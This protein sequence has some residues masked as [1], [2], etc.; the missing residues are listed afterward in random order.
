MEAVVAEPI[1]GGVA[2]GGEV[3]GGVAAEDRAAILGE[4]VIADVMHTV[5]DGSP[6]TTD[7][8]QE[9]GCVGS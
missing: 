1:E 9:C 4:S 6:V 2:E 5:F 7:Q 8:R 3:L